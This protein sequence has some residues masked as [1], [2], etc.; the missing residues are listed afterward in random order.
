MLRAFHSAAAVS[1]GETTS[2]A[3]PSCA[4]WALTS[5]TTWAARSARSAGQLGA[6]TQLPA[7]VATAGV[8]A[9]AAALSSAASMGD[10]R[11]AKRRAGPGRRTYR[12]LAAHP[13]PYAMRGAD[14][15]LDGGLSATDG[16]QPFLGRRGEG[17]DAGPILLDVRVGV[18]ARAHERA[19]GDVI[20]AQRVGGL[21]EGLELVGMPVAHH[22][23]VL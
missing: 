10:R 11:R 18:V 6:G 7:A 3:R 5:V 17:P 12:R 1:V 22:G 14:S 16:L 9:T 4:R 15:A 13:F 21:L 8:P 19:G 23:Q 2:G 20:E